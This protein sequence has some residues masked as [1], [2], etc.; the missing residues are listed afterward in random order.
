MWIE[1]AEDDSMKMKKDVNEIDQVEGL[2][3][4]ILG[5]C[6]DWAML[7]ELNLLDQNEFYYSMKERMREKMNEVA[8]IEL[9]LNGLKKCWWMG[10][11]DKKI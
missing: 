10:I 8:S 1:S 5:K 7:D 3:F 9:K 4:E 6:W 2:L 11:D